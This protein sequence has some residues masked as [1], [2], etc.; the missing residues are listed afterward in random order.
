MATVLTRYD[1]WDL[2]NGL[3]AEFPV[4]SPPGWD[5]VSLHYARALQTMGHVAGVADGDV[6]VEST[7]PYSEDPTSY[8]FQA[9]MHGTPRWGG[10]PPPAPAD[11]RRVHCPHSSA[12]DGDLA[13]HPYILPCHR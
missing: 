11:Q 9:A 1:I 7:W 13:G 8:H 10:G 12:A 3:V 2:N 5:A 6:E 4:A